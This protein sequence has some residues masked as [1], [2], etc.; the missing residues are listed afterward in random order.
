MQVTASSTLNHVD[1]HFD[2]AD[3]DAA[4]QQDAQQQDS[5]TGNGAAASTLKERLP[6]PPA[7]IVLQLQAKPAPSREPA[8]TPEPTH[9]GFFNKVGGVLKEAANSVQTAVRTV[10]AAKEQFGQSIDAAKQSL[11][12]QV[13]DVRAGLRQH[14]GVAGQVLSGAIGFT[15]GLGDSLYDAGKGLV[16]LA[17][18]VASLTSPVEWAAD[19]QAN[20]ARLKSAGSAVETLGRLANLA[21]PNGW[22]ADSQ[23]NAQLAGALWHSAATSFDQDPSKF[24]GNVIGTIGTMLIPG[25]DA[26]AAAGD[27]G[28]GADLLSDVGRAADVTATAAE[29][30]QKAGLLTDVSKAG[31]L[32]DASKLAEGEQ[33]AGAVDTTAAAAGEA[34]AKGTGE[35]AAE[36]AVG[37]AAKEGISSPNGLAYRSDLPNH[38]AGPDGFTK[39]GQLS[40]THNL[41]NATAALDTQGATYSLT[42]SGTT[43]ISE[44]QYSYTNAAGKTVTGSKTVYDPTIYSDQKMLDMAQAAGQRSYDLYLQNPSQKIF[45]I[46]QDG[47][48]FR[49]YINIDPKTGVPFVGNIHPIK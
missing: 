45:D 2:E 29:A 5:A 10:D 31:A 17:N 30:G 28:R 18:G 43:G 23:G 46:S 9:A 38:L 14:G 3:P 32:A 20:I 19:P 35:M 12:N 4:G 6:A 48:N 24:T 36:D 27:V 41:Q 22:L 44:L 7:S 1:T 11:E 15:E 34:A 42:P 8:K 40:G 25:A 21:N 47:I 39:S 13:D 49:A 33:A 37:V 16:Q 26:A